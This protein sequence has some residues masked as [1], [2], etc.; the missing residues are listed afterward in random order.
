MANNRL[1]PY[2]FAPGLTADGTRIETALRKIVELYNDIPPSLVERRWFPTHRVW[3]H[4]PGYHWTGALAEYTKMPWMDALNGISACASK[5]PA[6]PA[7]IQNVERVKSCAVPGIVLSETMSTQGLLTWEVSFHTTAPTILSCATWFA[8]FFDAPDKNNWTVI[9][10]GEPLAD[11]T[12]QVCVDDGWDLDSRKKLRQEALVYRVP[13]NVWDNTE[14]PG[15]ASPWTGLPV[16]TSI[17]TFKAVTLDQFVL[18]PE[19]SRVRIQC[20]IP[21]YDG[22]LTTWGSGNEPANKNL[23]TVHLEMWEP[24]R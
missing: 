11:V 23:W 19:Y 13:S 7:A 3:H 6:D 1:L 8:E 18:I 21:V 20:T 22:W 14:F 2:Q 10:T 17:M 5:Q 12:F 9:A 24:T 16:V 15:V 4:A